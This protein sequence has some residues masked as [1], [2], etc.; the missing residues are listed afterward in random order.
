MELKRVQEILFNR[1][2][3]LLVGLVVESVSGSWLLNKRYS[4]DRS[5]A[6]D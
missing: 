5:L 6:C 2:V 1:W 3:S 4:I